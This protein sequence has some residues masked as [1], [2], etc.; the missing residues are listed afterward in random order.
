MMCRGAELAVPGAAAVMHQ[1][2]TSSS[3]QQVA[4]QVA[5]GALGAFSRWRGGTRGWR[6]CKLRHEFF[7]EQKPGGERST[8]D[9]GEFLEI[10]FMELGSDDDLGQVRRYI[11]GPAVMD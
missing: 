8:G 4:L 3:H 9:G 10:G 11:G 5:L 1:R 6:R 2:C 7:D